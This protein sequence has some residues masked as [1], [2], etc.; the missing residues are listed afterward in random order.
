[1]SLWLGGAPERLVERPVL[2][3]ILVPV[4][5][6]EAL[7]FSLFVLS[8]KLPLPVLQAFRLLLTL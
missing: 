4:L 2:S 7:L 6:S 3:R 5:L 8:G 1:M